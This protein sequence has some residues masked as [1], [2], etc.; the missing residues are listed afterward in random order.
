MEL[1][2]FRDAFVGEA[3]ELLRN[4]SAHA[5][6]IESALK[7]GKNYG[8]AVREL[9]RAVHTLK[10]LG[11]MVAVEPIVALAHVMEESLRGADRNGTPITLQ[12]I[13][14]IVLGLRAIEQRVGSVAAGDVVS[15]PPPELLDAL[16]RSLPAN[17]ALARPEQDEGVLVLDETVAS[18]LSARD[19]QQLVA[20]VREGRRAYRFDFSPAPAL[21]EAG[22]TISTVRERVSQVG[23][24]VKVVPLSIAAGE[25]APGGL[26]FVLLVLS[27]K[28]AEEI[29]S[30]V[31]APITTPVHIV[32][33]RK[34]E[35]AEESLEEAALG[36]GSVRVDVRRL[37]AALDCLS[38]LVITRYRLSR[39]AHALAAQGID[40]RDLSQIVEQNA[41]E[42]RALRAAVLSLRMV[43]VSE[44]FNRV[45]LL[46]RSLGRSSN[47]RLRL[48]VDAGDTELD[49][50]V[51]ER[52][53]PAIVHLVRN[54]V[55]H[56]IESEAD[57]QRHGKAP[58]ALLALR[59]RPVSS[60]MVEIIV[61]DDGRGI[62]AEQVAERAQQPPPKNTSALL[63]I[64]CRPGFSTRDEASTT[65][66]RGMGMDIVKRTVVEQLGGQLQLETTPG[67]GTTFT[68]KVPL[69]I[70][71][72]DAF[73]FECAG[74]RF[75]VPNAM[76]EEVI[77][78]PAARLAHP[79]H[80]GSAHAVTMLEHRGGTVPLL[81]LS[82][83]L[84]TGGGCSAHAFIIK[85]HGETIA[86]GV[87]RIVTQQE[88][89]VRP[90]DDVLVKVQGV[91][92][93]TDL[94]DGVPTLVLDLFRLASTLSGEELTA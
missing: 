41:R 10:G 91:S 15:E 3:R 34:N 54:A 89:V 1:E 71:I 12:T 73:V 11:A 22:H 88:V 52:L 18:R 40:V 83:A 24:I 57:R 28:S 35:I 25:Q 30:A 90:L 60:T 21:A 47:K 51:A 64:L 79:P 92:G 86:F 20:G 37:D 81:R 75:T 26:T 33:V 42:L 43:G 46:V 32:T 17:A 53:F 2:D 50:G 19:R 59:C 29:V 62:L 56:G 39:A 93:A 7:K 69:T 68:L 13:D 23:D 55:D 4:A 8:R 31:S 77:E 48:E 58:E 70:S 63:E 65:S 5:L 9:F 14:A 94:G 76:I 61:S 36:H 67:A 45:R 85:N 72:V 82:D 66:G 80:M 87:D 74:Q 6:A 38:E 44:L 27:D 78:V 49:K 84:A 16:E